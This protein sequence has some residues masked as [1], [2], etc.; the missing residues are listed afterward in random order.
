MHGH[1]RDYGLLLLLG[2]IWGG[3]FLFIKLAVADIPPLTVAATRIVVGGAVL[4]AVAK[5]H[6]QRLSE[7]RRAWRP[8]LAMGALGTMLPFVLISWGETRID[9]GLAAILMAAVPFSTI[10]LAHVFVHDEP[11][12]WAKIVGVVL[13]FAGV[14]VLIGPAALTTLGGETLAEIAVLLATFCYA[15]N[16]IIAKHL[17]QLSSEAAGAGML[18]AAAICVVPFTLLLDRP[19]Q[20]AP[21]WQSL[22]AVITLGW[23]CTG[24]GYLLFFRIIASAGAGFVSLNNFLVPL[25]GVIWGAIV[26]SERLEPRAFVALI[27]ILAGVAAPRLLLRG[28]AQHHAERPST[29]AME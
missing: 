1:R 2:A 23:L 10:L 3:S 6:G 15:V 29:S 24:V 8:L 13:G 17:R 4:A 11:L 27:L 26:L 7:L 20:L 12:S 22:A 16:S 21:S 9:S 25:C 28:S 5:A 14:L 18:I 19:W